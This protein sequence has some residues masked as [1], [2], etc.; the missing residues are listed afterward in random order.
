MSRIPAQ[1]VASAPDRRKRILVQ[2]FFGLVLLSLWGRNLLAQQGRVT[3][4]GTIHDSSGAVVNVGVTVRLETL[5]G[6]PVGQSPVDSAGHFSFPDLN[7]IRYV[8]FVTAKGYQPYQ[9]QLNSQYVPGDYVHD[10]TLNRQNQIQLGPRADSARTDAQA[11]RPARNEYSKGERAL[12]GKHLR[13][14]QQHFENAVQQFPCYAR[15]QTDLA[16]VFILEHNGANAE[17]A[18]RKAGECDPDFLDSYIVLGQLLN[19][20]GKFSESVDVL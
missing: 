10:V 8:L 16:T 1:R 7:K 4:E 13:S 9:A 5:S 17:R 20:E 3:I 6:E 18:L 12:A 14:A 11:P 2:F 19:A 15:A